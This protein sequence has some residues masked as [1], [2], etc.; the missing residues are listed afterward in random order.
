MSLFP[1]P[2][3]D[4]WVPTFTLYDATGLSLLWTFYAVDDTNLPQAPIATVVQ[5]NL[6]GSG[7]VVIN[8][9]EKA[10]N[11]FLHFY[12]VDSGYTSVQAQI[13]DLL[14][15]IVVNTPFTLKIQTSINTI[16]TYNVKRIEDIKWGNVARDLRNY[17]QEVTLTLLCNAW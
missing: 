13:E 4:S 2:T 8:G 6:R 16:D 11:A 14:A 7:A 9:G 5:E 17:R 15:T 1:L 12:I 10:F 3:Y